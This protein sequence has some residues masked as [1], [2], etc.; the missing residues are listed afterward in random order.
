MY[1]I[2][3]PGNQWT[4]MSKKEPFWDSKNYVFSQMGVSYWGEVHRPRSQNYT[5][6]EAYPTL[7][8]YHIALQH[9]VVGVLKQGL[10]ELGT[11][12]GHISRYP[13]VGYSII[14]LRVCGMRKLKRTTMDHIAGYM[15]IKDSLDENKVAICI[16]NQKGST[17]S[18]DATTKELTEA[19]T[20]N[21]FVSTAKPLSHYGSEQSILTCANGTIYS[22]YHFPFELEIGRMYAEYLMADKKWGVV[23]MDH[24]MAPKILENRIIDMSQALYGIAMAGVPNEYMV[25]DQFHP[26]QGH[27]L[28]KYVIEEYIYSTHGLTGPYVSGEFSEDD[29]HFLPASVILPGGAFHRDFIQENGG[30]IL[31]NV[32][33]CIDGVSESPAIGTNIFVGGIGELQIGGSYTTLDVRDVDGNNFLKYGAPSV[34]GANTFQEYSSGWGFLRPQPNTVQIPS[35]HAIPDAG[36]EALIL[37]GDTAGDMVKTVITK[38]V[39]F[40]GVGVPKISILGNGDS[41]KYSSTAKRVPGAASPDSLG[42][43]ATL[44]SPRGWVVGS[45][46][47]TEPYVFSTTRFTNASD[48]DRWGGQNINAMLIARNIYESIQKYSPQLLPI[49]EAMEIKSVEAFCAELVERQLL[50]IVNFKVNFTSS[51]AKVIEIQYNW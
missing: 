16:Y 20:E 37:V 36:K 13:E 21:I 34:A 15:N 35:S 1:N 46:A 7:M 17:W 28:T 42:V 47:G 49:Y 40:E 5:A 39:N 23:T 22:K 41:V 3:F 11:H 30:F 25:S 19:M 2:T 51:F 8:G 10:V 24:P 38:G 44:L 33:K 6:F 45:I 29:S 12:T 27:G 9:P 32:V 18:R 31:T 4:R 50:G 43:V 26:S 48:G 14:P